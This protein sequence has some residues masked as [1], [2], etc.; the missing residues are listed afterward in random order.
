[1]TS[2][3]WAKAREIFEAALQVESAEREAFAA[4]A[5]GDDLSLRAGVE[6]LLRGYD[7]DGD[8][9]EQPVIA[10]LAESVTAETDAERRP[11]MAGQRIGPYQILRKLGS[12]GMGV[13][14]LAVR[15]DGEFHKQVAIKLLPAGA[16]EQA[17]SRF[18]RERQILADIEHPNIARLIDGGTIDGSPYIVMEYV[19][20]RNLRE[21]LKEQGA[22]ALDRVIE[23]TKQICAGLD[24]A[25]QRGIIHRDLKPENLIVSQSDGQWSVKILDF[26][27]ARPQRLD[28]GE[29]KTQTG[30][31]IGSAMYMS[32][33]QAAGESGEKLDARSDLYSL[34]AVIYEMLTGESVFEG[35]TYV[36]LINQH[37]GAQPKPPQDRRPDL[38]LPLAVAEVT[39]KALSKD[40]AN[41]QQSAKQLAEELEDASRNRTAPRI[42]KEKPAPPRTKRRWAKIL[43]ITA[44]AILALI[45][46]GFA[47]KLW[48]KPE[49]KTASGET[50]SFLSLQYRVLKRSPGGGAVPLMPDD[51]VREQDEIHFEITLPFAG[52]LYLLYEERDGWL[53][54]A[55]PRVNGAPQR[56][57]GGQKL[58]APEQ[59][60]HWIPFGDDPRKQHFLA[61]FVPDDVLWS[62]EDAVAPD[63]LQVKTEE[64]YVPYAIIQPEAAARVMNYLNEQALQVSVPGAVAGGIYTAPIPASAARNRIVFHRIIIFHA[65][66]K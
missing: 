9:L 49:V 13:V 23:I 17:A 1:M 15:A 54:W 48:L 3:D 56:G 35:E 34:G 11:Q 64:V 27:I 14:Y 61:V 22:L 47:L 2:V 58:R 33:E 21:I 7:E 4:Q 12:G 37:L 6:F 65:E 45:A 36:S 30:V 5:C 19:E 51:V 40:R 53:R 50:A 42:T 43:P 39:L 55:N 24:A 60:Q 28:T 16:G 44:A 66:K 25:H 31:I 26:G 38:N 57:Q 62:L 41:R 8:F 10:A 59:Q 20:G 52:A 63:R 18:R 32:P 46:T 29:M